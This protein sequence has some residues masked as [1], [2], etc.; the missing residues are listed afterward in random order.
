VATSAERFYHRMTSLTALQALVGQPE[1]ADFDC[2]EWPQRS[3]AARGTIAKAACGFANATGGVIVIGLKASGRGADMP[4]IVR[5][6]TPVADR[7]AVASAALDIILKFVEPGVQGVKWKTIPD[8]GSK[9]SGFILILIPEAEG[10]PRRSKVDW[11]FYVRVASGTIPMEYFQ[12]EERFGRRPLPRLSLH[13]EPL[14]MVDRWGFIDGPLRHLLFGLKNEGRG[15][16][17]FPGIR[18]KRSKNLRRDDFGVDG[19]AGFGLPPRPSEPDWI[20]FRGGVDDVIYPGETRLIGRLIQIAVNKGDKGVS[21]AGQPVFR[22][23]SAERLW[24]CEELALEYQISAEGTA[25]QCGIHQIEEDS[26]TVMI[27]LR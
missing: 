15:I 13:I 7:K 9:P 10:A 2:K 24:V 23:L 20:V 21:L 26:L 1:D 17:K 11:R 19:N 27:Q 8:A 22:F 3:D 12:V 6:I 4:D 16:A 25:T 5:N 18:F 14:Q